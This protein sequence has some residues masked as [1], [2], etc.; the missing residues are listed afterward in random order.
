MGCIDWV[1]RWAVYIVLAG[2]LCRLGWQVDCIDWVDR[3]MYRLGWQVDCIDW[4]DRW[5]YR[6]G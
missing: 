1:Y 6:L 3:W 2:G 5:M 4:V